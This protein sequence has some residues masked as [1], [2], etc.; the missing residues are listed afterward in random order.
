MLHLH[1]GPAS[2]STH[3]SNEAS[4][5]PDF[6][7]TSGNCCGFR[8][9]ESLPVWGALAVCHQGVTCVV[10]SRA[11]AALE[12]Q[13]VVCRPAAMPLMLWWMAS[14]RNPRSDAG[15]SGGSAR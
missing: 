14:S 6:R 3:I 4:T 12:A 7:R 15:A 13:P 5:L 9:G 11:R 8:T 10:P 1:N 2:T